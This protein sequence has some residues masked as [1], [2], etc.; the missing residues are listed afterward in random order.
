VPA[1]KLPNLHDAILERVLVDWTARTASV[2][3]GTGADTRLLLVAHEIREVR[4]DKREPW[5]PSDS[6]NSVYVD[7]S[8]ESEMALYIE[9]QSGDDILIVG[10]KLE[11]RE[12]QQ[13]DR[14]P[15]G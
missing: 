4:C 9:M 8:T 10:R 13:R 3:C 2:E 11:V 15:S 1:P 14:S 7:D 5:G 12:D 6:I